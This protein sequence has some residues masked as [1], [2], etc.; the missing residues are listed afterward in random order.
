MVLSCGLSALSLSQAPKIDSLNGVKHDVVGISGMEE[1]I[2][3]IC[4]VKITFGG[5]RSAVIE[6]LNEQQAAQLSAILE[7]SGIWYRWD[8][9]YQLH[10]QQAAPSWWRRLLAWAMPLLLV[11]LL[12]GVVMAQAR[13]V[14]AV[15]VEVV[16]ASQE[17]E[18]QELK[19]LVHTALRKRGDIVFPATGGLDFSIAL[20]ATEL[21][22]GKCR[23]LV[24]AMLIVGADRQPLLSIHTGASIQALSEHLVRELALKFAQQ[25][26]E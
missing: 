14:Q 25:G 18:A 6:Q 12:S 5:G 2:M 7:A 23:G 10:Q 22:D 8:G 4:N 21:D 11:G 3:K 1:T 15:R 19:R 16:S 17:P 26:R 20:T 9:T 24:A 13:T